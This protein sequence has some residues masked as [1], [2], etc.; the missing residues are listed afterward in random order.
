MAFLVGENTCGRIR[1]QLFSY[2]HLEPLAKLRPRL[3]AEL[4]LSISSNYA[5]TVR[6]RAYGPEHQPRYH[7]TLANAVARGNGLSDNLVRSLQ[8]L[9]DITQ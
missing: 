9:P 6:C 8:A 3:C 1:K 4:G 7:G 5:L 2:P